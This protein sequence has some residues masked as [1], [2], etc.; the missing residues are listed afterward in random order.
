MNSIGQIYFESPK[1][2]PS[3]SSFQSDLVSWLPENGGVNGDN[4]D[5]M[6]GDSGHPFV[7][8]R[9]INIWVISLINFKPKVIKLHV[10]KLDVIRTVWI[11][12]LFLPRTLF[13]FSS[14]K[15]FYLSS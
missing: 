4:Q 2:M 12:I 1:G 15:R 3:T 10:D 5:P 8:L 11:C 9:Y 6:F 13:C 14:A 7:S